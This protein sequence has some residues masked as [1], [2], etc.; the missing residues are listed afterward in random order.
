MME[1]T[2]THYKHIVLKLKDDVEFQISIKLNAVNV[3]LESYYYY[4]H[5]NT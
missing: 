3:I 1:P 4:I 5:H 2:K